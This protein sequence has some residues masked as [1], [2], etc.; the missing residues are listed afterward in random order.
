LYLHGVINL[1]T[2]LK[3]DI[4]GFFARW[5]IPNDLS[6]LNGHFPAFPV[7]PGIAVIDVTLEVL[8]RALALPSI[9][10]AELENAKFTQLI[11]P[12]QV[13]EIEILPTQDPARWS[14]KWKTNVLV[15]DVSFRLK[16][17]NH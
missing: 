6:Y 9:H 14:A 7:V 3:L 11:R 13:I 8:R 17:L 15:A 2:E 4:N 10:L 5:S 12:G 1:E 16:T